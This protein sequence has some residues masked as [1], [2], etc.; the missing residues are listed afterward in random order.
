MNKKNEGNKNTRGFDPAE[1]FIIDVLFIVIV[2]SVVG[3]FSGMLDHPWWMILSPLWML[4][5]MPPLRGIMD[6]LFG[7]DEEEITAV[8]AVIKQEETEESLDDEELHSRMVMA[9]PM[10]KDDYAKY[11]KWLNLQEEKEAATEEKEKDGESTST[12]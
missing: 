8:T 3:K 2:L 9:V 6:F 12:H 10:T 11:T 4:L 7:S 5:L 1:A